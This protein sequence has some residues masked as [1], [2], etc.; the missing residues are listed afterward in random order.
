M[1]IYGH[2]LIC[3]CV[4]NNVVG[5]QSMLQVERS[6][7]DIF[8]LKLRSGNGYRFR[9][10]L[11]SYY[12]P[13]Y[14]EILRAILN[15]DVINID[16]TPVKLRD[17]TGYVW[18]LA[19]ANKVY[20][21]Y[22]DS[23]EGSFLQDL[24]T[25]FSGVLVSDFYTAYDSLACRQQKCLVHLMRDIND[26]L[27]SH[28][29]DAELR[30]VADEFGHFL[31]S[32]VSSI[33]RWGLKE[34]HLRKHVKESERL[35][36]KV[37]DKR[38]KSDCAQKYQK[39]FDK[40]RESLFTFLI[41]DSVPWNNNNAEHAVHYFAK[42]RSLADGTFTRHSIEELLQIVSVLQTCE[43]NNMSPLRFLL[44]AKTSLSAITS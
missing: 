17:T 43:Y 22:R 23:R 1:T 20:Y 28:P 26:D 14:D 16:E 13:L 38:L 11:A 5:K 7:H 3:W 25:D 32:A 35:L 40:Y 19:S 36:R 31:A 33:D 27:R 6:L 4:Y 44:S 8:G 42:L 12:R 29:Y 41:H 10:E 15:D 2:G 21:L 18:V 34:C 39:R 9:S 30:F 24:L 37:I